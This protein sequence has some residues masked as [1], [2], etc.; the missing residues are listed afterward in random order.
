MAALQATMAG[1]SE[2]E[3]TCK[4]EEEDTCM[5]HMRAGCIAGYHGGK[6]GKFKRKP[7]GRL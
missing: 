7:A 2:E 1:T 6:V 4:S 5:C 3:D